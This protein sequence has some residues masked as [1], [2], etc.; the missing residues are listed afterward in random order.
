MAVYFIRRCTDPEGLIKI[1]FTRNVRARVKSLST[2]TPGGVELLASC[3]G[4]A[5]KEHDLHRR[6]ASD[7]VDGEW[8]RPS[9]AVIS[10]VASAQTDPHQLEEPG[11]S[12]TKS[13][14]VQPDD[15][16][17]PDIV[18][19]SR[20][21]LNELVKREWRGVGDSPEE[22]RNR[23]AAKHGLS[24]EKLRKI[25]YALVRSVD[26]DTYRVLSNEY[27]RALHNEGRAEARHLKLLRLQQFFA[28]KWASEPSRHDGEVSLT[29]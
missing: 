14:L 3:E 19:E 2:A 28:D 7:R 25:W 4:G 5:Q 24:S 20:F 18:C 10:A 21:Y 27:A 17:S 13:Y 12:R 22:A 15:E 16:F 6:Y 26:G 9:A 8:F 11:K 23:V 29:Q 1:G